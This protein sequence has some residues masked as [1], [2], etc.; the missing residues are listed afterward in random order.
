MIVPAK[1]TIGSEVAVMNR[2][3]NLE[4]GIVDNINVTY[5]AEKAP[6][7]TYRVYTKTGVYSKKEDEIRI[8]L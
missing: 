8:V 3:G 6:D 2:D 1:F 4:Y 7:V 5:F